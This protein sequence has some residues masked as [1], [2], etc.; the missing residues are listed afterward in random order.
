MYCTELPF[1]ARQWWEIFLPVLLIV[2][3]AWTLSLTTRQPLSPST[4]FQPTWAEI[5]TW[6][7]S[8][9]LPLCLWLYQG[10]AKD[11]VYLGWTI[12]P[13]Y[14][15]PNAGGVVVAGSLSANEYSC[16]HGAQMNVGD[17]PPYLT[18]RLHVPLFKRKNR[19]NNWSFFCSNLE[20]LYA[21]SR[22]GRYDICIL[23]NKWIHWLVHCN[24][25][26]FIVTLGECTVD[27]KTYDSTRLIYIMIA[28]SRDI[29]KD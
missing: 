9:P 4:A 27:V 23:H 25:S 8:A 16:A 18:K 2:E 29:R 17:L 10:A 20:P 19:A 14:M 6:T 22:T 12:V 13:S 5:T 21:C 24:F 26:Y 11:I 3:A 28:T 1:L 7:F 15:S